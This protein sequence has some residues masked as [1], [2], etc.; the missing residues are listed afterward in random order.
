MK[1]DFLSGVDPLLIS[2]KDA[3]DD[4]KA[5]MLIFRFFG[6]RI[7]ELWSEYILSFSLL[8]LTMMD[9]NLTMMDLNLK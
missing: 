3:E 4:L 8:N 5:G 9:L 6:W 2:P 7:V 1:V